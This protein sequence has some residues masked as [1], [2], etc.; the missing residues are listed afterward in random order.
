MAVPRRDLCNIGDLQTNEYDRLP[1]VHG[2]IVLALKG[3]LA[4]DDISCPARAVLPAA[5]IMCTSLKK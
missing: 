4:R 1:W 5:N 3:Q 2:S